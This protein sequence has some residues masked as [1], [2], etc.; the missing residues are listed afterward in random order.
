[1]DLLKASAHGGR[2]EAET[3]NNYCSVWISIVTQKH[4]DKPKPAN[5]I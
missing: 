1:V 2:L 4:S 5:Y 3:N